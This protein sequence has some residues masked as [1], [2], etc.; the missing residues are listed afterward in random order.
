M[1]IKKIAAE[2]FDNHLCRNSYPGRGLVVGKNARGNGWIIIYFIMGR[3]ENSRNRRFV[4]DKERLYTEPV[5]ISKVTDP[6]LII[7]DA[8]LAL[9]KIQI[10]SNGDQTSTIY[11]AVKEGN[12]FEQALSSRER[13]PDGPNFTPRISAML[14]LRKEN[15]NL[16]FS[17][18]KANACNKDFTDRY[19]IRP[20]NPPAKIGYGLTTYMGDGDPLPSFNGD[21]LILPLDGSSAEIL[22]TYWNAL[23][24]E[25]RVSL[26]VKE[27]DSKGETVS[28][29]VRNR[30]V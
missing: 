8:I 30:H 11:N 18:L 23:N 16:V 1:T 27:I 5:D 3:S 9:P 28:F 21:L 29:L 17:V 10:V 7:Y 12:S 22:D 4:A 2:I 14:D 13:E 19:T 6:S 25:N 24:A 20:V 15:D 26:A